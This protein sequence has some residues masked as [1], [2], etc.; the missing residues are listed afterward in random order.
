MLA[1]SPVR[2]TT[3]GDTIR[4]PGVTRICRSAPYSAPDIRFL[5]QCTQ[6]AGE[7]SES[8]STPS[9]SGSNKLQPQFVD[10]L[11][12]GFSA[13]SQ[14]VGNWITYGLQSANSRG[15][16]AGFSNQV[17]VS[18]APTLPAPQNI[19]AQTG[20][21]GITISW[22]GTPASSANYSGNFTYRLYRR[23]RPPSGGVEKASLPKP[24]PEASNEKKPSAQPAKNLKKSIMQPATQ[25]R[26]NLLSGGFNVVGETPAGAGATFTFIDKNF[27]WEKHYEYKVSAVTTVTGG[28]K[29][30]GKV[31]AEVEGEDSP[32]V[33][34][35]AH[36]V[37]PP[38][39]PSGLEAVF[40]GITAPSRRFIDLSW[41]PD[42]EPDL[43]GYNVYR[44][45]SGGEALKIN[46]E[47]VTTPSFRDLDVALGTT[48]FYSVSAVD[49][50]GNESGRSPEA[51]ET[52][53]R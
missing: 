45:Q 10:V 31:L 52:V 47:L 6:P 39:T 28:G 30:A 21:Q 19:A 22:S 12:P 46:R 26:L 51:S 36:D 8:F 24:T 49:V 50:R 15:R 44:R 11:R 20:A 9:A 25:S 38:G 23:L 16:S 42:S 4:H 13:N 3:E 35:F 2:T 17:R 48:F 53:P 32:V 37:F 33:E 14:D 18:L 40:S 1:W 29:D 7:V 5:E 27:E 34:V 41:T 43:A